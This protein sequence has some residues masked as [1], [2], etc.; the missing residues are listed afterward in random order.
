MAILA[1]LTL[2]VGSVATS[3]CG[4]Q[5]PKA[6]QWT[7]TLSLPLASNRVDGPYLAAHADIEALRWTSDSGLVWSIAESFDTIKVGLTMI[8]DNQTTHT[9]IA[10]GEFAIGAG[11]STETILALSDLHPQPTG[12]IAAFSGET[13]QSFPAIMALDSAQVAG[14]IIRVAVANELGIPL[15]SVEII[16]SNAGASQSFAVI[17]VPGP[18]PTGDSAFGDADLAGETIAGDWDFALRFYTPGGTILTASDKFVAISASLPEGIQ[19]EVARA[20]IDG[21]SADQTEAVRIIAEHLLTAA[22]FQGGTLKLEWTNST[23]LPIT[24]SWSSPDLTRNGVPL[25]GDILIDP[26]GQ[27]SEEYD[28]TDLAYGAAQ[29]ASTARIVIHIES[30]GSGGEVV[31][32]HASD[33]ISLDMT[34]SDVALSSATGVIAP[35]Q[36]NTGILTTGIDWDSGL[37]A[38]GLADWDLV[39]EVTSTLPMPATV[40]GRVATDTDLDLPFSGVI[41]P[42][43]DG[44]PVTTRLVVPQNGQPLWPLPGEVVFEGTVIYGDGVST[45][46]MTGTEFLV[47]RFEFSAASNLY[48]D[49]VSVTEEARAVV[50]FE[51]PAD[52][53][54]GRLLQ[55][56][57]SVT[58]SNGFPFGATFSLNLAPESAL[59]SESP[60]LVFGPATIA[61]AVTD[62]EGRAVSPVSATLNFTVDAAAIALFE[63]DTVWIG[64]SLTLIGPGGA[65]PAR[66]SPADA[67]D[68][69]ATITIDVLAGNK[70]LGGGDA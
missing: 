3:G 45:I 38:A 31:A 37:E 11:A 57:L 44:L 13:K 26:S 48:V 34:W 47:P 30:P 20:V 1:I 5:S 60:T 54:T 12:L 42:G 46:T 66:L 22:A 10:V 61:P 49:G 59:V 43:A 7:T 4:L 8:G 68:W 51:D 52:D 24:I 6:P 58:V 9:E 19:A 64:G 40:T 14:G 17:A 53:R 62:G 33:I 2:S 63:R 21:F 16:L 67:L 55:G 41:Q 70:G 23:P 18:I 65:Q 15:D 25:A 32:L 35:T 56:E 69:S 36:I 50:L 27:T 39:L 28:L 29:T